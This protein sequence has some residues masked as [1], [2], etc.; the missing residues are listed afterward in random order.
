MADE[1][2]HGV[3]PLSKGQ[4]P[5]L[6]PE[7]SRLLVA[8]HMITL[9][10][11]PVTRVPGCTRWGDGYPS[12]SAFCYILGR[13]RSSSSFGAASLRG[14]DCGHRHR[15]HL[16]GRHPVFP[17][18]SLLA[19][20]PPL[21]LA[22]LSPSSCPSFF[23]SSCCSSFPSE[24]PTSYSDLGKPL[25]ASLFRRRAKQP[26]CPPR[27]SVPWIVGTRSPVA[28]GPPS[29]F[30]PRGGKGRL[31]NAELGLLVAISGSRLPGLDWAWMAA[32]APIRR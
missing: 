19:P 10:Y 9:A 16:S 15:R 25:R 2:S 31:G 29:C 18:S 3:V 7:P 26:R 1:G 30:G 4:Y 8:V 24:L 14:F 6:Q 11:W 12:G 27:A 20:P 13:S 5:S 21:L 22:P 23:S 17:R 28:C 32:W